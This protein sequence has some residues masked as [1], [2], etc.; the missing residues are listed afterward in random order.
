MLAHLVVSRTK[1]ENPRDTEMSRYCLPRGNRSAFWLDK[2]WGLQKANQKRGKRYELYKLA[3]EFEKLLHNE[4]WP[5]WLAIIFMTSFFC[6]CG[7]RLLGMPPGG[8]V[9]SSV[10]GLVSSSLASAFNLAISLVVVNV[11]CGSFGY[12]W[13]VEGN[14]SLD[15]VNQSRFFQEFDQESLDLVFFWAVDGHVETKDAWDIVGYVVCSEVL[16][17][18]YSFNFQG[19]AFQ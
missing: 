13:Y 19:W 15:L 1:D 11:G 6:C 14:L 2:N 9:L 16:I 4:Y 7:V 18:F 8:E 12:L 5:T 17:T 10:S 3:V